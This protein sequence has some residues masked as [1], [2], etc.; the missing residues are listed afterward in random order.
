MQFVVIWSYDH[1]EVCYFFIVRRPFRE[2]GKNFRI[3]DGSWSRPGPCFCVNQKRQ[4]VENFHCNKLTNFGLKKC[5]FLLIAQCTMEDALAPR[6]TSSPPERTSLLSKHEI[7]YIF[8]FCKSGSVLKISLVWSSCLMCV[9][10]CF[11]WHLQKGL[12]CSLQRLQA[13]SSFAGIQISTF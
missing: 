4:K 12:S 3:R 9:C 1:K 8:P 11:G 5:Y 7:F 10:Q 2:N 13:Y 6:E